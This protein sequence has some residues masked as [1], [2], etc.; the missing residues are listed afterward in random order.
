MA[1]SLTV[2]SLTRDQAIEKLGWDELPGGWNETLWGQLPSTDIN[3]SRIMEDWEFEHCKCDKYSNIPCNR[4]NEHEKFLLK[5]SELRFS[6]LQKPKESIHDC[7]NYDEW[8]MYID[9]ILLTDPPLKE[10]EDAQWKNECAMYSKIRWNVINEEKF[11]GG[12]FPSERKNYLKT[13]RYRMYQLCGEKQVELLKKYIKSMEHV[14]SVEEYE[15][16]EECHQALI[17][18][19]SEFGKMVQTIPEKTYKK[20]IEIQASNKKLGR[21]A[22]RNNKNE[23]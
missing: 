2:A 19:I 4:E 21:R 20:P 23:D 6:G 8:I 10:R 7:K 1:H 16:S 3:T 9:Y 18:H 15:H 17:S 5:Q 22:K 14:N 12:K 11:I 13:A